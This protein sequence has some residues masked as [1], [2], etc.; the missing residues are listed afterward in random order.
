MTE[1]ERLKSLYDIF[2]RYGPNEREMSLLSLEYFRASGVA[3]V[4]NIVHAVHS[5]HFSHS[6]P[7]PKVIVTLGGSTGARAAAKQFGPVAIISNEDLFDK[8]GRLTGMKIS[9]YNGRDKLARASEA[10]QEAGVGGLVSKCT[11]IGSEREDI[12]MLLD[13]QVPIASPYACQEVLT[14]VPN[15]INMR[16]YLRKEL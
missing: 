14:T 4:F 10:M 3:E 7:K 8:K 15:I 6:M 16:D 12:E 13:A 11:V 1:I 5:I 2:A 9:M